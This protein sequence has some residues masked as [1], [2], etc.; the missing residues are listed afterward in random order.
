MPEPMHFGTFV[1]P[2]HSMSED[3]TLT[4][5]QDLE[6]ME[7]I[8]RLGYHEAWI[9]EHHS[10]GVETISSPEIFIAGAAAR[11]KRLKLGTGVIS[12][13]YHNPFNVANRIVQLDHQT[14]GRIM[15][16]VG[17]GLLA[18]DAMMLGIDPIVQRDRMA[19]SL[20]I[21]I[22]LFRGETVTQQSDW[23]NLVEAKLH[24]LPYS[25][26]HPEIA[27]ASAVTPSGGRLAGRY[28]LSMLCVAADDPSGFDALSAN[29][30]V[31]CETA[32]QSG[33]QMDIRDLRV[34]RLHI[35]ETKA[36]ALEDVKYGL[37]TYINYLNNNQ[38]R[39]TIPPG[40]DLA[41]WFCQTGYISVGT[42]D[43]ACNLVENLIRK[44]GRFGTFLIAAHNW[45]N[46]EAT[47]RSYELFARFVAP[48][49]NQANEARRAS[50]DW[51]TA[52]REEFSG[53]RIAAARAAFD[54]HATPQ[55]SGGTE[56]VTRP[57]R[58]REA[59]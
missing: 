24:I 22:R 55:P 32:A 17:P 20:E 33:H 30:Q 59:W 42:P 13:P 35:A 11:T 38:Q 44:Q 21:I 16:G 3:P 56:R 58:G 57:T 7:W 37:E 45:A 43:D 34:V 39:F 48:R 6:L 29:W 41:E 36:Q 2:Y 25:Y 52:N 26:P 53:K 12:L 31:A 8:E 54:K 27:V 40:V 50:Y 51:V 4:L 47:K 19:E 18:S 28:G 5:H 46:W 15:F 14:R 23:Y 10:A 9:G 1:A 49:I